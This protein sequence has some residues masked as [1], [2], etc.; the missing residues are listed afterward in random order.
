MR[1]EEF[2]KQYGGVPVAEVLK[3]HSVV[4]PGGKSLVLTPGPRTQQQLDSLR[5]HFSDED[6][7]LLQADSVLRML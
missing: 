5:L 1:K 3:L 6:W 4:S 7:A 2:E